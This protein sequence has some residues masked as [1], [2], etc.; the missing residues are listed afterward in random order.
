MSGTGMLTLPTI[1]ASRTSSALPFLS[2]NICCA[3]WL[4]RAAG[5]TETSAMFGAASPELARLL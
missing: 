3:W 2:S 1:L 4:M 5:V